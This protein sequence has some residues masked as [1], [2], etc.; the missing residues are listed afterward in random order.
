MKQPP[1]LARLT[2]WIL[3]PVLLC[4]LLG[5]VCSAAEMAS[6]CPPAPANIYPALD[7]APTVGVWHQNELLQVNWTPPP[8]TGWPSAAHSRLLVTLAGRFRFAGS[9]NALIDRIGAISSL[10]KVR[11]WSD[12]EKAWRP[13][14]ENASALTTTSPASR[15]SDFK[16]SEL[17]KGAELFYWENDDSKR[18]T[19]YRLRVYANSPDCFVLANE[20]ITPI[21]RSLF[22]IFKPSTLQSVLILQRLSAKTFGVY[23]LNRT[24]TGASSLSE[25]HEKT[26]VNRSVALYRK[27]VGVRTDFEP[28]QSEWNDLARAPRSASL[29]LPSATSTPE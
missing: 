27:L 29:K 21:K 23:M 28:P 14:A 20:N 11:Y 12:D 13:L 1:A 18:E 19:V 3:S 10:P 17:S 6:P 4:M 7:A 5:G 25:G 2:K 26:Y 22:T 9:M 8:C 15:R 16:A 24:D